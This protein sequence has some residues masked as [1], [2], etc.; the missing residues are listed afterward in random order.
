M[1][2]TLLVLAAGMGSRYGGLKQIDPMGPNGETLLDYSLRDALA[3]GF[4]R[5]VF[6]VREEFVDEFHRKI[7]AKFE[8]QTDLAYVRQELNDLPDGFVVPQGRT[9]PW[10][11]AHAVYAARKAVHDPFVVVNADDYYGADAYHR[12]VPFLQNCDPTDAGRTAMVGYPIQNTLSSHGTV[13][14]GI[15]R[16]EESRLATVEEHTE[17]QEGPDGIIRGLNLQGDSVAIDRD[18]LVSMNFWAFTPAL[19]PALQ[20]HFAEFLKNHGHEMKSECYIPSVI[21]TLIRSGQARCEVLP[22]T[23]DWFGVTYPGDK[24]VVQSRLQR[25]NARRL[26]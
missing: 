13:N 26:K 24:A 11:T 9:K 8:A 1:N 7:G 25:L 6:V 5:I 21:D 22:T 10:G 4:Q 12:V 18:S 2:P 14:R 15:C 16:L 20:D 23:G 19:F 3:A 17:L